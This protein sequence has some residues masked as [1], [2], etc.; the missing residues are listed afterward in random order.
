M[1]RLFCI[2]LFWLILATFSDASIVNISPTQLVLAPYDSITTLSLTNAD[3]I[4][5]TMQI[6]IKR[7]TQNHGKDDYTDTN[8]LIATPMMFEIPPNKT[9]IIRFALQYSMNRDHEQAYRIYLKEVVPH[10]KIPALQKNNQVQIALNINC[11]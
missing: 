3:Q 2:F 11:H 8:D 10:I 7:W 5:I 4:P 9:Q 6:D 1:L